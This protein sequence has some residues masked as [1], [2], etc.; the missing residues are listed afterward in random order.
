MHF[1]NNNNQA[2][3]GAVGIEIVINKVNN[4]PVVESNSQQRFKVSSFDEA[5][6]FCEAETFED[7]PV[8]S[9]THTKDLYASELFELK[10]L[11][12][13]FN[14]KINSILAILP[15]EVLNRYD[16]VS[17]TLQP[18]VFDATRYSP[19]APADMFNEVI[20]KMA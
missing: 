15:Q 8:S 19:E 20:Y 17:K 7:V 2:A 12:F 14:K 18:P 5:S 11:W 4:I 9:N 1:P 6:N 13:T 10:N 16:M 3:A